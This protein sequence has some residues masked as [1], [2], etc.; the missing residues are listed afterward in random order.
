MKKYN[1]PEAIFVVIAK[2]QIMSTSGE[3]STLDLGIISD[4]SGYVDKKSW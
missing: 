2:D 4:G 1:N 3:G